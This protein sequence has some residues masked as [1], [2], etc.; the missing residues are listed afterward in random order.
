MFF[1]LSGCGEFCAKRICGRLKRIKRVNI[2][3]NFSITEFTTF[4][5]KNAKGKSSQGG[6]KENIEFLILFISSKTF[7]SQWQKSF[8]KPGIKSSRQ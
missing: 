7:C 2:C 5:K 6:I 3:L 1:F 8:Q 4:V